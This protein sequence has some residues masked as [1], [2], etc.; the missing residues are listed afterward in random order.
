MNARRRSL[1]SSQCRRAG[2]AV[3]LCPA[4]LSEVII[5]MQS[6]VKIE[7]TP[8]GSTSLRE[9]LRLQC[10]HCRCHGLPTARPPACC[11]G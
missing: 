9:H 7:V 4:G 8:F 2:L 5:C 6:Y 11:E 1:R 3:N 10:E